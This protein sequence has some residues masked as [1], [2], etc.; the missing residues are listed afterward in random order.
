MAAGGAI[1][2]ITIPAEVESMWKDFKTKRSF[3]WMHL[4]LDQASFELQIDR[5]GAPASTA[6]E[7]AK[8]LPDSD[9]RYAVFDQVVTNK[10]GGTNTRLYC[11]M[12]SPPQAGRNN[13][14]Y[15][16]QR[17]S[18]DKFFSGVE[19]RQCTTRQAVLDAL[20]SATGGGAG[21]SA[22]AG[23]KKA[24]KRDDDDDAFDPDA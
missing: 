11:I 21:A 2:S 22:A 15:A 13:M 19:A 24:A 16:T 6:E 12:W 23:A 14:L 20:A 10:Y 3:R 17:K 5:T 7:F 4:R 9:A 18:L 8:A 1:A